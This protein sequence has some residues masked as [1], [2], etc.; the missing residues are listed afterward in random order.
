MH[1]MRRQSSV[2]YT[3]DKIMTIKVIKPSRW[4]LIV[5]KFPGDPTQNYLMRLVGLP[6]EKLYIEDGSV[7]INDKRLQQP[8]HIEDLKF[9]LSI[10]NNETR[11]KPFGKKD[12]PVTLG[13]DEYFVLGDFSLM[14]GDSRYWTVGAP[15]HPPYAVPESYIVGVA[16]H[17]YW[18]PERWRVL[19]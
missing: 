16:T 19:K 2:A 1:K 4:D 9:D 18:P 14:S 7:W 13:P 8:S 11:F 6:G 15:G 17:I 12:D 10:Q 5:F 3:G